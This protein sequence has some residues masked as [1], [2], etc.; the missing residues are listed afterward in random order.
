MTPLERAALAEAA[1]LAEGEARAN[2]LRAEYNAL[3]FKAEERQQQLERLSE[4]AQLLEMQP[5]SPEYAKKQRGMGSSH[6][7][8]AQQPPPSRKGSTDALS[9]AGS[10]VGSAISSPRDPRA[11]SKRRLE[12]R[13]R[14]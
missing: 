12:T 8:L 9:D 11:R 2:A 4:V 1:Q 7:S 5:A 10:S 6:A 3:S 14:R 13:S